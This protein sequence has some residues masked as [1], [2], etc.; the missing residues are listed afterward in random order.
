MIS[1]C[2]ELIIYIP[3]FSRCDRLRNC[4]D[5]ISRQIIG[6]E[7]KV[8]VYVS[9][10]AS[11]DETREYLESLDY[12]WLYIIHN[13]ENVGFA[14]N[15]FPCFDLPVKSEFVWPIGDD[16]YLMPNAISGILSLIK[17]YPAADYIF[18]NTKAFQYQ[19]Y[20][21]VLQNYFKTG[22]VDGG[23][24]KSRK[25]A[26]TALV[27]FERL[28]DP[29]ITDT[30]LGE[31]MVGC[32]RQSSVRFKARESINI[33]IY[34]HPANWE[35][36]D[37]ETAGKQFQPHNLPF[38]SCFNGKTKAVYCDVPR[39]FNFWGSATE[40]LGDYDYI[41]PVIILFL[42]SKY[43]ELGFISGEKYLELLDYYYSIMRGP[44]TRQLNG[45]SASRPFN[46]NIK[47]KM[48]EFLLFYVNGRLEQSGKITVTTTAR[49]FP[50][51]GLTSIVILTFNELKYTRECVESIRKR[52]PEP[53]E[54]IFV[55]NASTDGTV[56]WLKKMIRENPNYKLIENTKNLGFAKG[57][58][59]G[60]EASTGEY[61]LLLNNDVVVTDN[62]LSGMLECLN[63]AP[64]TGIVG[65]MTNNISGTQKVPDA[66]YR[67]MDRMHDYAKSFRE[68]YRHRRILLRRI[69]G[70][71]MLFR[72]QLV[73]KI[74]LMD[75]T[76]GTGNF[77][78]DDYCLRAT[79]AGCR[80]LIA[81][82]VF[83]HHYGSRS[84]IGNKIDYGSSI[85]GNIKIYDEKW[86]GIDVNTP[87]G[88]KVTA[89]NI[90][91]KA[92][93]LHQRG[94]LNSAIDTLIEGIKYAPE[95]KAIYYFLAEILLD[96]KLYKDALGAVNSMP[97]GAKDDLKRLE[98]IAYC[99]EDPDEAG[100][101]ADC[102]LERDKG[103][104]S[105]LNLKGII[106]HKQGDDNTAEKFFLQAIEADPGY[107]EPHTNRGLL[108]WV[109]DQK[110]EALNLLEKGFILSPVLTDNVT[111]YHSAITALDQFE[112]AEII[113]R[114]AKELYPE[115]KRILFF[116]IDILIKQE[117]LDQAMDE[118]ERAMLNFDI[119]DGMLAAAIEVRSRVGLKEIDKTVKNKGTLSLCM[120]VKN[121]EQHLARCLMSAKPVVD[122]MI[123][124]DTGSTDRTK[125]IAG[126]YGARVFDFPWTND[127]S[128]ARNFSLSMAAGD[129][130]LV[131][132]AD[133]VISPQDYAALERIVKKSPSVPVAFTMCTRNYTNEISARG[134]TANDRK[135]LREEAGAGWFPSDKVRLFVNDKR[136]RFQNPVHE[137]VEASLEKAG[138]EIKTLGMP[139]HHYGRFDKDKLLEKGKEYFLLGMKKMEE[140]KGDLKAM[141]ELAIQASELGEYDTAVELWKKVIELNNNDSVAFLNIGYA[142]L[143]LKKYQ[144]ALVV[145]R[146]AMELDPSVKE[147]VMNYADS[148]FIIG[149]IG[150]TISVLEAL[151]RKVPDY[152]PAM[153]LVAAAYYVNGRKEEGLGLFEKLR[154]KGFDWADFIT[155]Q[156]RAFIAQGRFDE[157][158]L[159]LEIAIK[160]RNI[161][162]DTQRLLAELE[163]RKG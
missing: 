134:W 100:K 35:N 107:G 125:D 153:L 131:L 114:D 7:D 99:T 115:N 4:L 45:Q 64:D 143:K 61:A 39:T 119:D 14:L 31:I 124:V 17:E 34:T 87:L 96:D 89:V 3:T 24:I 33:N 82:D 18:C 13:E 75:E 109:I 95:E 42:I 113:F 84:F 133:E 1:T 102:I 145:S 123:V 15:I 68:R 130:I 163:S 159:L 88:K 105:A 58:N 120:I 129:W 93:R 8:L 90:I 69:V 150:K 151:L 138:I 12:K 78:D 81:A 10:N 36:I 157:A 40:W 62:W 161:N 104:A 57:C 132:D 60:I 79:L 122:E 108:K 32:F 111:L 11:T 76:F 152:P 92:D 25:Y 23:V 91:G 55:D 26:G 103:Y 48:Y 146:R 66:D 20:A 49:P 5:V 41:F 110:E 135:Y 2:F 136:I 126:A 74:G 47:A 116:L 112:R 73:D 67:T 52:T 140:M 44:L 22:S 149:D 59:Q 85:S 158:I 9:N 63:S 118:I 162:K 28:I 65:P 71:C 97:A 94:Q 27:D 56:K 142:Y 106:A 51:A 128:E 160:T 147:A 80:N 148:E 46:S 21:E 29:D 127:F 50:V 155:D 77:E 37:F 38:L 144:E 139:V 43:K 156:S 83:I 121:E 30:L 16:D 72:R 70:F 154:K 54:V 53:H 6:L 137:F 101:Y 141:K 86:M 98:I 19:R 117:K